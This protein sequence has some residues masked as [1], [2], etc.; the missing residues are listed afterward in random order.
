M[1]KRGKEAESVLPSEIVPALW[2]HCRSTGAHWG[3]RDCGGYG[4][5]LLCHCLAL[6]ESASLA[7][8]GH[9]LADQWTAGSCFYGLLRCGPE[10]TK[11]VCWICWPLRTSGD[12]HRTCLGDCA[13]RAF[14]DWDRIGA[15]QCIDVSSVCEDR[16]TPL[17]ISI[18]KSETFG[19][20]VGL[21]WSLM[22]SAGLLQQHQPARPVTITARLPV[23]PLRT[24]SPSC[25]RLAIGKRAYPANVAVVPD[26]AH[27]TRQPLY[28]LGPL[29]SI[30]IRAIAL[31]AI[32]SPRP[33][34]PRPSVVVAFTLIWS[35]GNSRSSARRARIAA[36]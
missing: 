28:A 19:K 20:S 11:C 22:L 25:H 12:Q 6:C 29:S 26:R 14:M 33:V 16:T 27:C 7:W 23:Q 4:V 24:G 35:A 21:S 3:I 10:P 17:C 5:R 2:G 31:Q 32:P 36:T 8:L 13:A 18:D 9:V 15:L 30:S 1:G 34:N